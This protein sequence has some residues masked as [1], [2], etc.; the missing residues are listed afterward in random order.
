MKMIDL[1]KQPEYRG[2]FLKSPKFPYP[3]A[4]PQPW[5]VWINK[6]SSKTAGKLVWLRKDTVTFRDAVKFVSPRMKEWEDFSI[7]SRIIGFVPPKNLRNSYELS[8]WCYRCRRPVEFRV[9]RKHHALRSDMHVYFEDW[10]VCPFCGSS[11]EQQYT[12]VPG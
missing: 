6:E 12:L 9:F 1:L 11:G 8:D 4:C 2:Y 3:L 10:P 7:T 5:T